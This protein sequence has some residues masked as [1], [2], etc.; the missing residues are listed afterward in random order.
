MGIK[1]AFD[2]RTNLKRSVMF[3]EN[4]PDSSQWDTAGLMRL[5]INKLLWMKPQGKQRL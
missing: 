5:K 3:E 1:Y 2:R 4:V